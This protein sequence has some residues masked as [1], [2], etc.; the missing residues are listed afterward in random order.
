MRQPKNGAA[1]RLN[2]LAMTKYLL[3]FLQARTLEFLLGDALQKGCD[4]I[5]ACG[6]IQS[7]L[8]RTVAMAARQLGLQT[9]LVLRWFEKDM[10]SHMHRECSITCICLHVY[11]LMCVSTCI[12][13]CVCV[14][15]CV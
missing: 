13:I 9:H 15:S 8:A 5:V 7:N 14:C 3:L 2:N 1:R 11:V 10:V 4:S 12:Y 6:N